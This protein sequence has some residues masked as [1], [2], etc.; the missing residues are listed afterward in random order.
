MLKHI[1]K[2]TKGLAGNMDEDAILVWKKTNNQTNKQT[3]L[4]KHD[5]KGNNCKEKMDGLD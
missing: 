5:A 4:S 1:I 3:S 2:C